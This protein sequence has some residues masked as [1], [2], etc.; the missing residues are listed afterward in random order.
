MRKAYLLVLI[1][2]LMAFVPS[3]TVAA[4]ATQT[5]VGMLFGG[6]WSLASETGVSSSNLS[7]LPPIVEVY[8]ATWCSNCVDVEHALDNIENESG[9]QQYHIH[10]AINE[11]QD[12]LGSIEI[13]QHFIDRY[14]TQAPPAVIFNGTTIKIGSVAEAATLEEEFTALSDVHLSLIGDSS[15][16]WTPV[17]QDAGF[18]A[19]SLDVESMT[20]PEGST[21]V[22]QAWIVEDS[23]RFEDGSNGL[24]N[25]PHVVRGIVELGHL[26]LTSESVSMTGNTT[27]SLPPAYDGSDLSVHLLYQLNY[28]VESVEEVDQ[29]NECNGTECE[30]EEQF[31]PA[32]SIL[33]SMSVLI[34][35][36]LLR[37]D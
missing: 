30:D 16:A 36:A 14:G 28:P 35:V 13:D 15:F 19:W 3:S 8:T 12:P 22:A 37:N 2:F 33:M 9:I 26:N 31:I 1:V 32:A 29:S 21:I 7:E 27:V 24:E 6:Q 17:S 4:P 5:D 20:A 25:Y 11:I 18:V 23:A 10:R 34:G